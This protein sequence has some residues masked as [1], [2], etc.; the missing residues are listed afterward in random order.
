MKSI[1]YRLLPFK[2]VART[3]VAVFR[4]NK[5]SLSKDVCMSSIDYG[6]IV[7]YTSFIHPSIGTLKQFCASSFSV[8]E[9]PSLIFRSTTRSK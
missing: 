5:P 6:R 4:S 3:V 2:T 7:I 8:N 9:F 1:A